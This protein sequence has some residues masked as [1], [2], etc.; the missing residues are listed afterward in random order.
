M[1]AAAAGPAASQRFFQSLSDALIDR[2]PQAALEVQILMSVTELKGVEKFRMV[3]K[4]EDQEEYL[5]SN[6][7][8][9]ILDEE[10]HRARGNSGWC[11]SP[12]ASSSRMWVSMCT[13]QVALQVELILIFNLLFILFIY[14]YIF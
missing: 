5:A 11:S 12:P 1:A 2:D 7:V 4:I 8:V 6:F 13:M 3:W 14:F 10:L 9:M